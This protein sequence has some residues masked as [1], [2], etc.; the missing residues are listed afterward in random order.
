MF[1]MGAA[2]FGLAKLPPFLADDY[3]TESRADA[4]IKFAGNYV[5][6]CWRTTVKNESYSRGLFSSSNLIL[7]S[8]W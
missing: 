6:D 4:G 8:A 3:D 1:S 5:C 2:M 7:Y